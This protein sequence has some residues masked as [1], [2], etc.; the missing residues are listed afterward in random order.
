MRSLIA[1]ESC[2]QSTGEKSSE[3]AQTATDLNQDEVDA[4]L[5]IIL[6]VAALSFLE[7]DEQATARIIDVTR[8]SNQSSEY[9]QEN[10]GRDVWCYSGTSG[11]HMLLFLS[12]WS[13]GQ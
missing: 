5:F 9:C 2:P 7:A 3:S 4:R 12:E 13:T 8:R 1:D 11:W 10:Y 6:M